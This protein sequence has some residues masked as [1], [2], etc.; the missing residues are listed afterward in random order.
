MGTV[1]GG[2]LM[3]ISGL[4]YAR[5]IAPENIEV[6]NMSLTLPRLTPS[7]DGYRV[8]QIS[9]IHMD[10]WMTFDRLKG[11]VELVNEQEA[12]LIAITGDFVTRSTK[13]NDEELVGALSMLRAPDG[14]VA[15]L[16]NHDHETDP[17]LIRHLV[18]DGGVFEMRNGFRTLRRG[19]DVLHIAGVDD[20]LMC[21][22]R[23][24]DILGELPEEGTAILLA[25][26]PD[27]ADVSAPTG[28]F[29]LQ[30]SGHSHGGQV[31]LPLIGAPYLPPYGRR[32]PCGLYEVN[33]MLQYTN[34]GLGMFP[35]HVRFLC[36]P[37]IT[38][39]ALRTPE[40]SLTQ[41]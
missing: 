11:I 4:F 19:G 22:A 8:V 29:D 23:L 1:I 10:D 17:A 35:P 40:R 3:G 26:E 24:Y 21:Q 5:E 16:G 34:R 41:P 14:V 20:F 13:F 38:V 32:Y 12:D 9:D 36:R 37:E 31:R 18:R 6:V 15:V 27:F 2:T 25:H 30:L 39:F 28:R 33:G 7:F